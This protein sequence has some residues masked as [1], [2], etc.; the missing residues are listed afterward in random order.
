[1]G[2][3]QFYYCFDKQVENA[4]RYSIEEA[5]RRQWRSRFVGTAE[6][7]ALDALET[8]KRKMEK[9]TGR[10]VSESKQEPENVGMEAGK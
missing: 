6:D 4:M 10:K 2:W 8:F 1:M 9:H 7:I 5:L 3:N